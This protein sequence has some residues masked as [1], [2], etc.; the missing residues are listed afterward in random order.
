M[1][2]LNLWPALVRY[3]ND[4]VIEI[5]NSAVERALRGVAIARSVKGGSRH[6]RPLT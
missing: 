3:C 5:D 1:Y 4:G 2:A 6:M